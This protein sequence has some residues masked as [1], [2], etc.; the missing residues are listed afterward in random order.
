MMRR[1][2]VK[3][4]LALAVALVLMGAFRALALTVCTV[5]GKAWH[6]LLQQGDRLLVNRW[7]YGLRMGRHDGLF[8]YSRLCRQ[9]VRRGDIVVYEDPR[10]P[11]HNRWQV[12]LCKGVPGDS[13]NC[14]GRLLAVPGVKDCADADYY[15]LETV[16]ASHKPLGLV[17]E[18]WIIGR[19][20]SVVYNHDPQQPLWKGWDSSRWM[21]PR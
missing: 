20:C 5:E 21:L 3:F 8:G 13:V 18:Q 17:S 7:S 19:V 10:D 15:W 6:P 11:S 12:G 14:A 1:K 9:Q 4:L 16:G 2:T